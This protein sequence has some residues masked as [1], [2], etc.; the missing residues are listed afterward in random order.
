MMRHLF[1]PVLFP[2]LLH[3]LNHAMAAIR[4]ATTYSL[5]QY[6]AATI[7]PILELQ[8]VVEN[9]PDVAEPIREILE[10]L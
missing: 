4:M 1:T 2:A 7:R 10:N 5:T 6:E 8:L 3:M 9:E